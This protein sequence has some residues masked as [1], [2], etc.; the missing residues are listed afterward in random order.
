MD[1]AGRLLAA[2]ICRMVMTNLPP[3]PCLDGHQAGAGV[4]G[5]QERKSAAP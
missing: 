1:K 5:V 4:K 2:R 3:A